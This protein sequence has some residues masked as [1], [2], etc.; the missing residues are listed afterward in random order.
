MAVG[1]IS[2]GIGSVPPAQTLIDIGQGARLD[3]SLYDEPLPL[4]YV[5]PAPGARL[6]TSRRPS[7]SGFAIEPRPPRP[8]SSQASWGRP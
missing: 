1:L 4:L 7:G 6:R 8:I 2:A 5:D 3:P